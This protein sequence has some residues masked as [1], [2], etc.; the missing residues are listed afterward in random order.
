[1]GLPVTCVLLWWH[2]PEAHGFV[3]HPVGL[4]IMGTSLICDLSYPFL[5]AHVKKT[6]RVLPDGT[7][8]AGNSGLGQLGEADKKER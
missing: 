4:I 3:F 7:V 8:V 6:E 1:M 2:W 5:L